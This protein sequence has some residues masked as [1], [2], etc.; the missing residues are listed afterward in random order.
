GVMA[1][2]RVLSGFEGHRVSG[3]VGNDIT[4][5]YVLEIDYEQR[6]LR[7]YDPGSFTYDGPGHV[8]PVDFLG[9]AFAHVRVQPFGGAPVDATMLVDIGV[10]NAFMLFA[11]F[12]ARNELMPP[13]SRAVWATVGYGIGGEVRNHV[14]RLASCEVGG[15]TLAQPVATFATDTSGL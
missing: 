3:L 6:V 13:P 9:H 11:P 15:F 12:V 8:L 5:R 10:R 7:W 14:G 2:D 1:L 4:S